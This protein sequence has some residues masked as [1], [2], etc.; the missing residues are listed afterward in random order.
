[1]IYGAYLVS[2]VG[3]LIVLAGLYAWAIEPSAEPEDPAAEPP[4]A[5]GPGDGDLVAVG[6]GDAPAEEPAG[7]E[8]PNG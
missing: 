8:A 7:E 2:V 1:M 6:A 4:P 3:A 5:I